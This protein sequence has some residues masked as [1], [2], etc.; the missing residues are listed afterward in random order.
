MIND[1][2]RVTDWKLKSKLNTEEFVL[3]GYRDL[4]FLLP[5]VNV[6]VNVTKLNSQYVSTEALLMALFSSQ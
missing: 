2:K 1:D 3:L 4:Y 6:N 5:N